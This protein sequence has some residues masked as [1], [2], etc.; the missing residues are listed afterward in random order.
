MNDIHFENLNINS[1]LVARKHT[2]ATSLTCENILLDDNVVA[3]EVIQ[4]YG[5]QVDFAPYTGGTV[6]DVS[7]GEGINLSASA[8]QL[9]FSLPP[10]P[11][12]IPGSYANPFLSVNEYGFIEY[13]TEGQSISG[14]T[15]VNT[16]NGLAGGPITTTGTLTLSDSGVVA[17]TISVPKTIVVD[18]FGRITSVAESSTINTQGSSE[19]E[20]KTLFYNNNSTF[21]ALPGFETDSSNNFY[22]DASNDYKFQ[23]T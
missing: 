6:S 2:Q 19:T 12:I 23:S 16:D 21:D 14:I 13:I 5:D 20:G 4:W 22:C 9:T 1:T 18:E 3:G 17:Q 15:R 7:V 8:R 11:N 10:Q